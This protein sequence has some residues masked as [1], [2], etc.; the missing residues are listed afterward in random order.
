[1]ENAK[2]LGN[3]LKAMNQKFLGNFRQKNK[4]K[5][6]NKLQIFI[7]CYFFFTSVFV[8]GQI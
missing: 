1:L 5:N 7:S 4:R 3:F 2:V 6:S 8:L